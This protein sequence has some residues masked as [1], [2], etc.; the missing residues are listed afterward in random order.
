MRSV[1]CGVWSVEL[2][3]SVKCHSERKRRIPRAFRVRNAKCDVRK[4]KSDVADVILNAVK[5]PPGRAR[6]FGHTKRV[7]SEKRRMKS[8][9]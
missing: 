7:K 9:G 8:V 5:D 3:V 6:G 2:K 1:K 4:V